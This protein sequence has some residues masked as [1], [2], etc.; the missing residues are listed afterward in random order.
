MEQSHVASQSA[1]AESLSQEQLGQ[2]IESLFQQLKGEARTQI[3][4]TLLNT[5]STGAQRNLIATEYHYIQ[6]A[7]EQERRDRAIP[8]QKYEVGDFAE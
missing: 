5:L 2:R 8:F 4:R 6:R 1:E 3:I 7:E